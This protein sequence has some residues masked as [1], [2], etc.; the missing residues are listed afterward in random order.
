MFS[1]A[2]EYGIR[3]SI[4][5]AEQSLLG[6]KV[7]LKEIALAVDSP[8]AYTS[9]ILQE[10]SRNFIINSDKGPHGGFSMNQ[11][12]LE[13]VNLSAVI[14]TIDGDAI[15]NGCGLGLKKC[16]DDEPCPLHGQFKFVRE[17]LR[18]MLENT[19]IKSLSMD[20]KEGLT[21]LKR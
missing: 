19:S 20:L 3:A 1:K 4:F 14:N 7:G 8:E 11:K 2:C 9:K 21:F 17:E 13:E 18:K 15:Y 16:G 6:K 10:L 12:Q 5:I